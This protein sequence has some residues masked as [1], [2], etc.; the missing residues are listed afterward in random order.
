VPPAEHVALDDLASRRTIVLP[1]P[2]P[3]SQER[4]ANPT[5]SGSRVVWERYTT[6][7]CTDQHCPNYLLDLQMYDL[8]SHRLTTLS[9]G[10][11]RLGSSFSP[12]LWKNELLFLHGY[13]P[14]SGGRVVEVDLSHRVAGAHAFW[15][16]GYVHRSM[17]RGNA[18][19]LTV[20][21]G[22]AMWDGGLA[23][24]SGGGSMTLAL[25]SEQIMGGHA[26]VLESKPLQPYAL[27]RV[28]HRCAASA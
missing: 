19:D 4:Y 16:Q 17:G 1:V 12:G 14:E 5:L 20:R 9:H 7:A 8:V 26:L 15:W 28:L 2:V 23:D 13:G 6:F 24:L 10:S 18:S 22:L 25:G 11:F 27:S 3:S 21:D